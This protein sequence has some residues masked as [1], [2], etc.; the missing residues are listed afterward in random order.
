[1]GHAG[2]TPLAR[3]RLNL[4]GNGL[5]AGLAAIPLGQISVKP[6]RVLVDGPYVAVHSKTTLPSG[7]TTSW[8]RPPTLLDWRAEGDQ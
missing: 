4:A 6:V 3:V 8:L 7:D 2:R 1:M 5:Q